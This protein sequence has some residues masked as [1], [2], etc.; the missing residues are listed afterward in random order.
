MMQ[1]LDGYRIR[2]GKIEQPIAL[3]KGADI[4]FTQ[5]GN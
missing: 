5:E 1:D 4:Y 3:K 2:I